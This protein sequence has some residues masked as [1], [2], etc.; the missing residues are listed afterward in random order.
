MQI[1]QTFSAQSKLALLYQS[2]YAA[3]DAVKS[4]AGFPDIEVIELKAVDGTILYSTRN[5]KIEATETVTHESTSIDI[6]E[7]DRE[8]I[9]S[10]PVLSKGDSDEELT[11]IYQDDE[12]AQ[13]LLGYV[14]LS[15]SKKT[16]HLMQKRTYQ[17]SFIVAFAIAIL[18]ILTLYRISRRLTRPVEQL[19]LV[20]GQAE[21]G[22]TSIRA[23]LE[24]QPDVARMQHAFNT[25]MDG[26]E[27]R[28]AELKQAHDKALETA[29]VKG[30]FVANVTHELRTPLNAVL[31][32]MDLLSE[33]RLNARQAEYID[34]A[35]NSG[36]NLL[37]LIEDILD[38]SKMES[39]NMDINL[40]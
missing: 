19:A 14:T 17:T 1:T 31:G 9:F 38:F 37:D 5:I 18:I 29:R 34:I 40:K 7:N 22:N 10:A 33:T 4:I 30:E 23:T 20:M 15:M 27:N 16:L 36:E 13:T 6:F 2:E 11:D 24:G 25:M 28:E 32:M 3:E 39:G 35:K 8:W 26:I 21:E 12:Q